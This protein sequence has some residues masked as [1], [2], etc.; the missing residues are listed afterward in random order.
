M[1]DWPSAAM[2]ASPLERGCD[3][4]SPKKLTLIASI[5]ARCAG[6]SVASACSVLCDPW[7]MPSWSEP[8]K[9][10]CVGSVGV[11]ALNEL[12]ARAVEL[13]AV[14]VGGRV[15]V[16]KAEVG[17]ELVEVLLVVEV[18]ALVESGRAQVARHE[19]HE[20]GEQAEGALHHA[21]IFW[22]TGQLSMSLS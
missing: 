12:G 14:V 2:S 17:A 13:V 8:L 3:T 19:L 10:E 6:S 22:Q 20:A 9:A 4:S 21:V 11:A 18:A 5:L 1:D 15:C 7:R 16:A